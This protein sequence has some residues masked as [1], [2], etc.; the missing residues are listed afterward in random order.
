MNITF[1]ELRKVKDSLPD[2]TMAKIAEDL[3]V[4]VERV[5]NYF[6]GSTISADKVAD[7]HIEKGPNGGIVH[8]EDPSIFE[9]AKKYMPRSASADQN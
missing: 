2:G 9:M 3:G 6:G 8:L 7:I 5:R 4:S 1:N